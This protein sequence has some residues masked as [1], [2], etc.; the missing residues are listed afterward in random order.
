MRCLFANWGHFK[1]EISGLLQIKMIQ[2]LFLI[3]LW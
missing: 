3:G 2:L 1:S